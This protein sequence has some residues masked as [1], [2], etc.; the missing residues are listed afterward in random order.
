MLWTLSGTSGVD[1]QNAERA[2]QRTGYGAR[3]QAGF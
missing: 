2:I 3:A 1:S